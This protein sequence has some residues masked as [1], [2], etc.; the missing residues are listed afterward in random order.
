MSTLVEHRSNESLTD[1][2][3]QCYNAGAKADLLFALAMSELGMRFPGLVSL[4][5]I[6]DVVYSDSTIREQIYGGSYK[7][8]TT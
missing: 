5:Q 7:Q 8:V 2:L 4:D 1:L 3:W 6:Y